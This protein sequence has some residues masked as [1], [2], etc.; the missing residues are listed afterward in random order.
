MNA[1]FENN[2]SFF[3]TTQAKG[4]GEQC[5]SMQNTLASFTKRKKKSD[6]RKREKIK[7]NKLESGDR[8]E[9]KKMSIGKLT[10][11]KRKPE[12]GL[13]ELFQHWKHTQLEN[14]VSS[15]SKYSMETVSP[16]V[17]RANSRETNK[18]DL[19]FSS[20]LL[21]FI[22][23]SLSGLK[24]LP[25]LHIYTMNNMANTSTYDA[26]LSARYTVISFTCTPEDSVRLE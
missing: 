24:M 10:R 3:K 22:H 11:G 5:A 8:A 4:I 20:G 1:R 19:A 25:L 9:G 12:A 2:R 23:M 21:C 16:Q 26:C 17:H 18:R 7:H 13:F 15:T 6:V 14:G